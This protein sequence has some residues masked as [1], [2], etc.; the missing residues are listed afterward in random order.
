MST[1]G[2]EAV[3]TLDVRTVILVTLGFTRWW[4][5][6][7]H[8]YLFLKPHHNLRLLVQGGHR[9]REILLVFL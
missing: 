4:L 9:L 3:E 7:S 8:V 5:L 2:F 6:N 1:L